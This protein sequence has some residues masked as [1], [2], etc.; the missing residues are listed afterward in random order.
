VI[1]VV[2]TDFE[3]AVWNVGNHRSWPLCPGNR[4]GFYRLRWW[5]RRSA[6]NCG[7]VAAPPLQALKIRRS[8]RSRRRDRGPRRWSPTK[9]GPAPTSSDVLGNWEDLGR[10]GDDHHR[11]CVQ[12]RR[13]WGWSRSHAVSLQGWYIR[14]TLFKHPPSPG[15]AILHGIFA[16]T[17][18]V[19][20]SSLCQPHRQLSQRDRLSALAAFVVTASL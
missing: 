16:V 4:S 7:C 13:R 20:S 5:R 17:S 9:A 1:D 19:T 12:A 15:P 14:T 6:Y 8:W 18:P 10:P 11:T 2:T 3:R